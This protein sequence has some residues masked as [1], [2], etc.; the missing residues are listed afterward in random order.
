[1]AA[2]LNFLFLLSRVLNSKWNY[3]IISFSASILEATL[4]FLYWA[5]N[6]SLSSQAEIVPDAWRTWELKQPRRICWRDIRFIRFERWHQGSTWLYVHIECYTCTHLKDVVCTTLIICLHYCM[7]FLICK[8]VILL[9]NY[10]L[11][12]FMNKYYIFPSIWARY[13]VSTLL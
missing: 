13:K 2:I 4:I 8:M 7:Q 1:M 10:Q 6:C 9:M 12:I 11:Y 5:E 3:L